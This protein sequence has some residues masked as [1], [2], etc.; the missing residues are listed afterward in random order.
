MVVGQ[1][2]KQHSEDED[3]AKCRNSLYSQEEETA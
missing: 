1:H 3:E 2:Q